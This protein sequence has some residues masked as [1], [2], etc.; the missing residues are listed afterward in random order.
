MRRDSGEEK[1][2]GGGK[3]GGRWISMEGPLRGRGSGGAQGGAERPCE[4]GCVGRARKAGRP[5]GLCFSRSRIT[6][7]SGETKFSVG[8][9]VIRGL[10]LPAAGMVFNLVVSSAP[11]SAGVAASD[12]ASLK[13]T[14]VVVVS[15]ALSFVFVPPPRCPCPCWDDH[16]Y[17]QTTLP[18]L[19]VVL[20]VASAP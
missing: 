20:W 12:A 3:R 17:L 10:D 8:P 11:A 15:S 7:V 19:R 1:D 18:R 9:A 6:G 5:T 13:Q 2:G 14:Q 4:A 16:F